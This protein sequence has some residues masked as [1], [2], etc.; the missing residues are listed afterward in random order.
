MRSVQA[1]CLE[2]QSVVNHGKSL[3]THFAKLKCPVQCASCVAKSHQDSWSLPKLHKPGRT[4][5]QLK[6]EVS[7][8]PSTKMIT[9][10]AILCKYNR[11]QFTCDTP[12]TIPFALEEVRSTPRAAGHQPARHIP[13]PVPLH[14]IAACMSSWRL[15]QCNP[16]WPPAV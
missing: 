6:D 2:D 1:H 12:S 3:C 9:E 8:P 13:R 5:S 10:E 16:R 11:Q 4:S 14:S 15:K 7:R